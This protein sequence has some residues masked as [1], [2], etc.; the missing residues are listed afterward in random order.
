MLYRTTER[1]NRA[2]E[3]KVE[4]DEEIKITSNENLREQREKRRLRLI[5]E[6]DSQP[7][8]VQLKVKSFSIQSPSSATS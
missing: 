6:L 4:R 8:K 5:N 7:L 3:S 2:G 1:N